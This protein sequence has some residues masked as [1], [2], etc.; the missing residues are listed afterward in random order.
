M[1]DSP[2]PFRPVEEPATDALP[3]EPDDCRCPN[4]DDQYLLEID[5]SSVFLRHVACGKQ[6]GDWATDTLHLPPTAVTMKWTV[7]KDNWTGEVSDAWAD[8]TVNGLPQDV[9]DAAVAMGRKLD[10]QA[11]EDS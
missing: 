10:E 9:Q 6:V 3:F 1:T 11:R 8:L 2:S 4:P 5:A 7:D